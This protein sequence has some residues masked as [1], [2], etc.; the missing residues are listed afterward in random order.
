V[1][2]PRRLRAPQEHGAILAEPAWTDVPDLL[3]ANHHCLQ[4]SKVAILGRPLSDLRHHAR[5]A[6]LSA[7]GQYLQL[8]GEPIPSFADGPL[9]LAGHQPELFHP[10]VWVK[11]F[12][13]NGLAR[14]L[15]GVPLN[16]IVDSDAPKSVSLSIP[17]WETDVGARMKEEP[18]SIPFIPHPSSLILP[19]D[20]GINEVPYEEREV[21]DP[22][23]FAEFARN[24]RVAVRGWSFPSM[25]PAFW[26]E[27]ERQALR[28]RL[29]GERLVGAR[30]FFERSWGCHNFEVRVSRLC[31]T[32]PFAWFACHLLTDLPHFH[33]LYNQCLHDYRRV[34]GLRSRSH[35]VPDLAAE[36]DW[37][38]V[39]LWGWRSDQPRRGRLMA[40]LQS[41][42]I[43][44]RVGAESWPTIPFPTTS[45]PARAV[46][47]W[48]DLE[49]RGF[50]LRSR[51][52]TTTL[53]ARLFVGD[54]FIHGIGGAK[55]DELTDEIIRRFYGFEPPRFMILSATLRLPFPLLPAQ[56]RDRARLLWQLRDLH[57]N[58]QRY[59][60]RGTPHAL[61]LAAQKQDWIARQPRDAR[62]RRE[63]FQALQQLTA[64]LR[65]FVEDAR[66]P[67]SR[68]LVRCERQLQAN[69]LL[70]RR[71]YVFCLYP[72]AELREFCS[73]FLMGHLP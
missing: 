31:G 40:R 45:D 60:D 5:N 6:A 67:V 50:K 18:N 71:D 56:P 39:P 72:E 48:Q 66:A 69:V 8:A 25:L 53:F 37:L 34:Y 42:S 30:R 24:A 13:L 10:G 68:E 20:R 55:Y 32:E 7:A 3:R 16:L 49:R 64:Q 1:I 14:T 58:P 22:A 29:L 28:T 43:D 70:G 17:K 38:E 35:P 23:V 36:G 27:V 4:N 41:A 62:Q 12:A 9:L 52:L 63:R 33:S 46:A 54:V 73:R 11:N 2:V 65:S 61:A 44:L 57:C 21:Q 19:F 47:A 51:A 15:G 59:V 26:S